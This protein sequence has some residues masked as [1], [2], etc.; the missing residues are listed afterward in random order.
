MNDKILSASEIPAIFGETMPMEAVLLMLDTSISA[1]EL[2]ERFKEIQS[3]RTDFMSPWQQSVN[4]W[5]TDTFGPEITK[6]SLERT[7]R[8]L[9]EALE[10]VQSLNMTE[11]QVRKLTTY[12]F[13]RPKGETFQEIGSTLLT[14]AALTNSL[15]INEEEAQLKELERVWLKQE[16][17]RAKQR[18][19]PTNSPLPGPTEPENEG[20]VIPRRVYP[21]LKPVCNHCGMREGRHAENCPRKE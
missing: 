5:M 13:S 18:G 12:V 9:E 20:K 2:R 10:L 19:K 6:D 1:D 14:L 8:F 17:I 21:K 7:W 16:T 3:K 11:E 15:G 4:E